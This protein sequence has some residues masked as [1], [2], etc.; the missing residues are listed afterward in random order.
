MNA[1]KYVICLGKKPWDEHPDRTQ[2]LLSHRKE[3]IILYFYPE[4][5]AD[6]S[7]KNSLSRS[8]AKVGTDIYAYPLPKNFPQTTS[9]ILL[10]LRMNK[11]SQFITRVMHKHHVKDPILWTTH[12]LH[13]EILPYLTF[14]S[15][16]Y[17]CEGY[18]SGETL[19]LLQQDLV[20]KAD[21]VFSVSPELKKELQKQNKNVVLLRNGVDYP[22][23]EQIDVEP[24]LHKQVWFGF[25]GK[26]DYDLDL[27]PLVYTARERPDWKF[28]LVGSCHRENP[29]LHLLK[30]LPN[31]FFLGDFPPEDVA[32][33]LYSCTVLMDFRSEFQNS[34]II[35]TR[36]Y[37]YFSTGKPVVAHLWQ[38]QV[39]PYPDVIYSSF[40]SVEFVNQC[41]EAL[42]ERLDTLAT[43]RKKHGERASWFNRSL[44][45]SKHFSTSGF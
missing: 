32:E 30:Q 28:C 7:S 43:R 10:K 18:W 40:S 45:V 23:Y 25:S 5:N 37:Q 9:S 22:L 19:Q 13:N 24:S 11:L 15:L 31:V 12:P 44:Q 4:K 3:M 34:D 2:Y 41:E 17:D 8:E 36:I 21:L 20:K 33:F 42:K 39:E 27:S 14:A 26:M 16:V 38:Q 29:S 35:S 1:K 6:S